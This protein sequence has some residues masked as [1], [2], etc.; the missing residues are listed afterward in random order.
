MS[1]QLSSQ[2][3]S[4]AER[5]LS[6]ARFAAERHAEHR[7]KNVR[8]DPYVNHL[9]EVAHLLAQAVG[10]SDSN[11]IMAGYLHDAVEDVG[12]T[13]QELRE[14][15]G[16]D[17]AGLVIEVTDDKRLTRAERKQR[18]IEKA[19]LISARGQWLKQA[20]KIS[21]L[22]SMVDAPPEGWPRE[23]IDDYFNWSR[24]VVDSMTQPHPWLSA[25][26]ERTYLRS[27]A[28]ANGAARQAAPFAD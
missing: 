27:A 5:I 8:R 23:R 26:F 6:A 13:E 12:V 28:I 11:L 14:L 10:D 20:D 7:R 19:A 9:I 17:V 24:R 25:E 1:S 16:G 18:Q 15:F 3:Q 22:R 21:N 4:Q 2:T